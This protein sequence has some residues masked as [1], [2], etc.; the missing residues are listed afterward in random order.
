MVNKTNK[1]TTIRKTAIRKTAIRKTTV[2]KSP[3]SLNNSIP[4]TT[5]WINWLNNQNTFT[6]YLPKPENSIWKEW[7]HIANQEYNYKTSIQEKY[8]KNVKNN[9]H[10]K[11]IEQYWYDIM[12]F[13]LIKFMGYPETFESFV[14]NVEVK[15]DKPK[16]RYIPTSDKPIALF[17]T[18]QHWLS[19][20]RQ[21]KLQGWFD[22]YDEYQPFGTNQL[23]QTFTFMNLLNKLPPRSKDRSFKVYYEYTKK[24][25]EFIK[26][27]FT[28]HPKLVKINNDNDLGNYNYT[29]LLFRVNECIKKSNIFINLLEY[30]DDID[31]H[32]KP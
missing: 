6:V 14:E 4:T 9:I 22:P 2:K 17:T 32:P 7:F 21:D 10:F 15:L 26:E 3:S 19:Y 12:I 23:C 29:E 31:Y 8:Q 5:E 30:S 1:K 24:G 28:L 18:G 13:P 16:P 25:F 11:Y 20:P 27:L